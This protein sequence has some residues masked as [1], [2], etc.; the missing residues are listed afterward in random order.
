MH[1]FFSLTSSDERTLT[2]SDERTDIY[3]LTYPPTSKEVEI[4]LRPLKAKFSSDLNL[5]VKDKILINIY[6]Y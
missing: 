6:I 3:K 4:L 2:S 5:F 1:Q